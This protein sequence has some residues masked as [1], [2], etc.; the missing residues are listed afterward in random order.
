DGDAGCC[1]DG[2]VD[3]REQCDDGNNVSLDG[4]AADCTLENIGPGIKYCGTEVYACGDTLDNDMDGLID[5]DDPECTTPCD[6][7][8]GT[9]KTSLPGQ[10]RPEGPRV[11]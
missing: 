9:F 11:G 3:A 5:L 4:C 6:D 7:D 2:L 8:E 1:G 10:N